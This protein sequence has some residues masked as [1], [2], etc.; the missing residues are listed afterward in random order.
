MWIGDKIMALPKA[1]IGNSASFQIS[2]TPFVKHMA[3]AGTETID[4]KY[5]TRAITI[6]SASGTTTVHFGDNDSTTLSLIAGV[7]YRFEVKCKKLVVVSS[8]A[9]VSIVA[10]L[11]NVESGQLAQ[12]DQDDWATVP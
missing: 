6:S 7:V 9:G 4:F 3:G 10:E 12:H 8:A 2:G 5:V 1:S 11:T